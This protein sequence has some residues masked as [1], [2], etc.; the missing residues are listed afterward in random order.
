MN[1]NLN[2]LASIVLLPIAAFAPCLVLAASPPYSQG[3][4][5]GCIRHDPDSGRPLCRDVRSDT[6]Y[7]KSAGVGTLAR[8][9]NTPPPTGHGCGGNTGYIA[10]PAVPGETRSWQEPRG[11]L[12]RYC[13]QPK[14]VNTGEGPTPANMQVFLVGDKDFPLTTNAIGTTRRMANIALP[15]AGKDATRVDETWCVDLPSTA[16]VPNL[17]LFLNVPAQNLLS[18]I[19]QPSGASGAGT[20]TPT[21]PNAASARGTSVITAVKNN[22]TI[23]AYSTACKLEFSDSPGPKRDISKDKLSFVPRVTGPSNKPVDIPAKKN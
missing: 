8:A 19:L 6:L 14:V 11:A 20:A 12:T 7:P 4:G 21:A 9:P 22:G 2:L 17:S 3:D 15:I 5:G 1:L 10:D 23:K 16:P 18:G 13:V